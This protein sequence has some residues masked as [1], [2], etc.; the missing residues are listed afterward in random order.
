MVP[1][2]SVSLVTPGHILILKD[3]DLE[4][5]NEGEQMTFVFLGLGYLSQGDFFL[6][7][8]IQLQ[9]S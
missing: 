8:S 5:T 3:L 2:H 1:F 7:S 9:D 6:V 4:T